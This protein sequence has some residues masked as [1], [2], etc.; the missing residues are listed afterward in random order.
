MCLCTKSTYAPFVASYNYFLPCLVFSGG[1]RKKTE[2]QLVPFLKTFFF[3]L[4]GKEVTQSKNVLA[5]PVTYE[6]SQKSDKSAKELTA[7]NKL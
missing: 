6:I 1:D 5:S 3:F 7:G 2:I 4:S